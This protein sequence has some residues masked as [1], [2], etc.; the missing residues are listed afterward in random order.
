MLIMDMKWS[1]L[2]DNSVM[3]ELEYT[4]HSCEYKPYKQLSLLLN[5]N[6][7]ILIIN[8]LYLSLSRFVYTHD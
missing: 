7:T 4:T 8:E 6:P 5:N 1:G 2:L 3:L